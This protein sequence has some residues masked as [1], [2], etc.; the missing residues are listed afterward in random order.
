MKPFLW[1]SIFA[2]LFCWGVTL[3]ALI[4]YTWRSAEIFQDFGTELSNRQLFVITCIGWFFGAWFVSIPLLVA[5][6]IGVNAI[7]FALIESHSMRWLWTVLACAVPFVV[8]L[9]M[10]LTVRSAFSS[11]YN[12]LS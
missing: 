10:F 12:E 6:V 7:G 4:M 3:V 11:L 5:A 8:T 1:L 9:F 2:Q